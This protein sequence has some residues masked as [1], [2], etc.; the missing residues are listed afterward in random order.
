[1]MLALLFLFPLFHLSI[2]ELSFEP[3]ITS[4]PNEVY[5]EQLNANNVFEIDV[6]QDIVKDIRAE[7]ERDVRPFLP[8]GKSTEN[9]CLVTPGN[10]NTTTW[11]AVDG[12]ASSDIKWYSV[13]NRE[14]YDK[15]LHHVDRLRLKEI[16]ARR[17][18]DS[19]P[20]DIAV[21]T[22]FLIVRSHT[23]KHT[24]H[25]DWSKRIQTQVLNVLIP[26]NDFQLHLAY[27]DIDGDIRQYEYKLGKAIGFGGGFVHS[28][29]IG[30]SDPE[31]VLLSVYLGS[32][33]PTIWKYA[34]NNIDDELEHYM[35]PLRG[36]IHNENYPDEDTMCQ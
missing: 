17:W 13:N 29:E 8:T 9:F 10:P 33:D 3:R 5:N 23:E 25:V 19:D 36:F 21:Y 15:Y 6:D 24:F 16:V 26:L 4:C 18:I 28:T 30:D 1:M 14:T 2:A 12:T 22:M 7:Y 32:S 11:D 31:D 35:S 34:R 20:D 27:E